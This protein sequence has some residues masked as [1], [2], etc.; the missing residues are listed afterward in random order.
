M[1]CIAEINNFSFMT[2]YR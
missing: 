1:F 2:F